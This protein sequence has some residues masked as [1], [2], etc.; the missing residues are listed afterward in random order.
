M[1]AQNAMTRGNGGNRLRC[2][3]EESRLLML[4]VSLFSI[5]FFLGCHLPSIQGFVNCR[6]ARDHT[7]TTW[8]AAAKRSTQG[9]A[10]FYFRHQIINHEANR[11]SRYPLYDLKHNTGYHFAFI[12]KAV[13]QIVA[14]GDFPTLG[15]SRHTG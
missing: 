2:L 11:L 14:I 8:E 13:F 12:T 6:V 5:F 1:R 9:D 7:D 10:T 15:G 3:H 4:A